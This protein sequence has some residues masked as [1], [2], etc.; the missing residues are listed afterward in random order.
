[1]EN[2][3]G[4]PWGPQARAHWKSKP[5]V[6]RQGRC[7]RLLAKNLNAC[8]QR[9][10]PCS[11]IHLESLRVRTCVYVYGYYCSAVFARC[12][13]EYVYTYVGVCPNVFVI[14]PSLRVSS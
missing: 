7:Y 2:P 8:P 12:R 5:A 14:S 3:M 11:C 13:P 4:T 9:H 1:M 6:D 10:G